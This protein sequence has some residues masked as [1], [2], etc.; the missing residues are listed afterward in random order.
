[1]RPALV[2]ATL[3]ARPARPM[4]AVNAVGEG[5]RDSMLSREKRRIGP[6]SPLH[7][8][9]HLAAWLES[10]PAGGGFNSFVLLPHLL[11]GAR[12]VLW[13]LGRE[14]SAAGAM[15][16]LLLL[17]VNTPSYQVASRGAAGVHAGQP[18]AA[19]AA[20]PLTAWNGKSTVARLRMAEVDKESASIYDDFMGLDDSGASVPLALE[21]KEK[22]YLECLDAFYNEGGKEVLSEVKYEQLKL[23]LEFS[24]RCGSLLS[25][26]S[27]SAACPCP[28]Y[29]RIG[30]LPTPTKRPTRPCPSV[31]M[32]AGS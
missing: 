1:M 4:A 32:S 18:R 15:A 5:P 2:G 24:E 21:E 25:P 29:P 10:P 13:D 22:L 16:S 8:A 23:D 26:C 9:P 6:P 12:E 14:E 3:K 11:N 27:R 28:P 7:V 20:A 31:C 19:A 30:R 17:T